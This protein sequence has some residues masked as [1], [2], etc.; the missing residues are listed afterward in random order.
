[1]NQLSTEKRAQILRA[2]V[3][4]NSIRATVRMTG[5]AKNT[6]LKLLMDVGQACSDYQD[7]HMR[8][9]PC[10]RLQ[11]DEIRS[12]CYAKVKNV[13]VEKACKPG[14]GEVWT[15]VA[16]DADTKIVPTW[17]IGG[18]DAGI[19]RAFM[20]DLAGRLAHRVQLTTDG[21]HA[22]LLAVSE[23]FGD[24]IDFGQHVKL[25]GPDTYGDGPERKYRPGECDG[26]RKQA[27]IGNPKASQV[28]TS[29]A[30]RQ[31]LTMRMSMRRFTQLTNAF[32]KKIEDL[33][34]AVALHFMYYNY[35]RKH[36][37]L[38]KT[39]AQK[40]GLAD[41]QW[42]VEEILDLIPLD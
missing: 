6:V 4:G 24:K 40:A 18:R 25:Y 36:Q 9:L 37:T 20:N 32:S 2:A 10:Q 31:N 7:R 21:H 39:P 35:C 22:N 42:S 29:F 12:F 26:A 13:P 3:E 15:W 19:G 30:G 5:A 14:G 16:I 28:S 8:N 23:A 41:H 17:M 34:H 1:M 33:A 38:N 27:I 11:C